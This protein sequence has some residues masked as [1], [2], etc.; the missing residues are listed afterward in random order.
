MIR[1]F[2]QT[3]IHAEHG[4]IRDE[5]AGRVA[6]T[7]EDLRA[8]IHELASEGA[9][10]LRE[11]FVSEA[12]SKKGSRSRTNADPDAEAQPF[13]RKYQKWYS[14]ALKVVEQLLPDRYQE[15]RGLHSV[16]RKGKIPDVFTYGIADYL[17]GLQ[18]TIYR[19]FQ[20]ELAFDPRTIAAGK[21]TQQVLIVES[22]RTRLDSLL[23]D[24]KGVLEAS[25]FDSELDA[26][27]D[28]LKAKHLRSAG[29]VAGV[30]LERHLKRVI[31][32]HQVSFRKIATL[33][34]LNQA[35]KDASLL[36]VPQWRQ[37]QHL[38]DIR[39]LC[40]HSGIREPTAE[41]VQELIQGTEKIVRTVF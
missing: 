31:D 33:S 2:D 14:E 20:T 27:R 25:L 15:F 36:D 30:V 17:L 22:T 4:S 8:A 11:E 18:V 35:L 10:L 5:D 21:F 19:N 41:E 6:K 1:C 28:L 12:S 7:R 16:D 34:N 32:N 9:K 38:G 3:D 24:I 40:G 23:A 29:I 39:N 26:A 13:M 37:L